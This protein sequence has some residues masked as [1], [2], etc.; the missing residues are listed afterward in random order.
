MYDDDCSLGRD[1]VRRAF[2]SCVRA[3]TTSGTGGRV[4]PTNN[5][6]GDPSPIA[7]L[8]ANADRAAG[9]AEA[10]EPRSLLLTAP[11]PG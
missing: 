10:A 2:A 11:C 8:L 3:V 6:A 9:P 4:G 1:N 7:G 5:D